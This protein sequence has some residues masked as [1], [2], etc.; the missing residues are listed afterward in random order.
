[1]KRV[2]LIGWRGMV[3]SVLM[4]RMLE[5]RDFDLIEPVFFTTSNVGGEGPAVGKETA[6]LKDAYSIDELK[7][8]DVIL[9]C[10]G[11]DYTN[12][13]FPRLREAGWQGYW[14]DAASSLRMQDDAVI[15]LDPVN[16]KV[17]DQSLDAG[18]KNYIGGNCTVSLMLMALGGLF[19][20]GL[21]EWMSAMT[22]QAASGAGAQNMRELIKQ[23]GAINASVADDL[24]NPS[25][26]IL[27]IDRKVA[28]AIRS[29]AM[30]SEH[31]G[32][33]LAGS[34]IPW[35]DKELPN[36]QSREEWKGQAETN[37][38]LGRFKSPIPVDGICVRI[39]AMRCHSQALTI[40]LNKDVPLTD[41]EGL[42]SQHNPW[43]KLIPNQRD[44]SMRELTPAAVTGTLSVPVGRLRKLNMGSQYLGA[45]TVGDQ[46]LW[47]AAEPLRRMLR[48]LLER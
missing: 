45:F 29:E 14:I 3:G 7:T 16:R 36:G 38:I 15:V 34:L 19:E 31:F 35:I 8:L 18:A 6:P 11:G 32:V 37:K 5:E 24:A 17:I 20:A 1:M 39:G 40:K 21:V 42:I 41:I 30:P 28:E 33:P 27:D 4:Q 12:E 25:S 47:G 9:T 43:V 44:I 23:M 48:I 2:G 10:Q 22:Y 46:L 26:A 13:V